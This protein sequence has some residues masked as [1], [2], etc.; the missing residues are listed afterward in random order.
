MAETQKWEQQIKAET[1]LEKFRQ[2]ALQRHRTATAADDVIQSALRVMR[3]TMRGGIGINASVA[4][5]GIC[6][7]LQ[8][9]RKV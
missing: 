5:C 6:L 8:F 2:M 3:S 1:D 9:A 4:F 7:Y